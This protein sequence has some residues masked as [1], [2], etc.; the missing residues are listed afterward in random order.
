MNELN[1]DFDLDAWL[2]GAKRTER[3][4]ILY[5]RADLLADIDLLE[6]QQRTAAAIPEEDRAL[7]EGVGGYLQDKIDALYVQMDQSKIVLRV[8]SL[9][10]SEVEEIRT[11]A[12]KELK[13][14][15]D[16]AAADARADA[17][18]QCERA[19]ITAVNDINSFV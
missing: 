14:E 8:R 1:E 17:K 5:G 19:A 16:E 7:G 15:L 9:T 4:V 10:D 2:D 3:A 11:A 12:E 13:P 18:R 6:A